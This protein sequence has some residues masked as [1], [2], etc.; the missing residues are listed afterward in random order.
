M[1]A[2]LTPAPVTAGTVDDPQTFFTPH[3]TASLGFGAG[4]LAVALVPRVAWT[5][6]SFSTHATDGS[7][8]RL[9][10]ARAPPKA[11]AT[12]PRT[13]SMKSPR[14]ASALASA[15]PLNFTIRRQSPSAANAGDA[16]A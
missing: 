1:I 7:A 3:W 16:A 12:R 5:M 9:A 10:T 8:R 13:P 14:R 6:A 4:G 2:T 11:T 15:A